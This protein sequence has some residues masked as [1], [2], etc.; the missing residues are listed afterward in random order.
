MKVL[1]AC[2]GTGGHIYPA[3][4]MAEELLRRDKN[5]QVL[6]TGSKNGMEKDIVEKRGFKFE[7]VDARPLDRGKWLK[8][9]VN[10]FFVIKSL[11][12][13]AVIVARFRPEAAVGT[14]GFAAFPA[15]LTAALMGRRT[16]IHEPNMVPGLANRMLAPFVSV[17]TAGF[18]ETMKYFPARK[19]RL[20]GNPVRTAL[21]H[22]ERSKGLKEFGLKPG[23]KTVL[24]MPGSRAARSINAAMAEALKFHKAEMGKMQFIWMSG[25]RDYV[26]CSRAAKASGLKI[27]VAAYV[28][29]AALAYAAADAAVLR[30]GASTLSEICAV[31]MPAVLVPYPYATA[32]HQMKNARVLEEAGAVLVIKDSELT[33]AN[34]IGALKKVLDVK[35]AKSMRRALKSVYTGGSA[36]KIVKILTGENEG[37]N[38]R[39]CTLSG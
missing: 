5:A 18:P 12:E 27:K 29:N 34:L 28:D 21:L 35:K 14:G 15:I 1:F 25:G 3:I 33:A 11:F 16:L 24:I 30:A 39:N 22:R 32:D 31:Q 26:M 4:A 38:A 36:A 37:Q 2:G 6:F 7:G 17:V 13:S 8:N 9:F 10:L 23:K 19:I 20:T